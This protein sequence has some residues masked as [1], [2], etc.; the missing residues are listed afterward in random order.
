VPHGTVFNSHVK[1][2]SCTSDAKNKIVEIR[3]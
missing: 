1:V 3:N 2:Y